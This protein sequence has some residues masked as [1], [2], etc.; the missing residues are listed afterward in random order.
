LGLP[1][2]STLRGKYKIPTTNEPD[3]ILHA[4]LVKEQKTFDAKN[5]GASELAWECMC[6]L[7]FYTMHMKGRMVYNG[8]G[9]IVGIAHDAHCPKV[10]EKELEELKALDVSEEQLENGAAAKEVKLPE[11]AKHFQV[12]VA[13]TWSPT[14]MSGR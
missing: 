12:F 3:A 6:P 8:Q 10:L 4:N 14:T 11:L 1:H 7:K 13:S 5:V 9:E 2:D